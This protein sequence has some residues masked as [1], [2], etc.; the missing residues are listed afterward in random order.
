[1]VT[2][3]NKYTNQLQ[4]VC[5]FLSAF[6]TESKNRSIGGQK[7]KELVYGAVRTSV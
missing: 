7:N 2:T 4:E 1:M 3:P 6:N 5:T